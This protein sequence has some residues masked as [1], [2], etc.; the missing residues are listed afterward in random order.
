MFYDIYKLTVVV[1]NIVIFINNG[2]LLFHLTVFSS[3]GGLNKK[4]K[5]IYVTYSNLLKPKVFCHF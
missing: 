3:C 1:L 2:V 5:Y 4:K